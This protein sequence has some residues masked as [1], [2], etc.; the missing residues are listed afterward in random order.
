M[1]L[2]LLVPTL[3]ISTLSILTGCKNETKSDSASVTN[4]EKTAIGSS[5]YD[6]QN[7]TVKYNEYI[8]FQ[9]Y[10]HKYLMKTAQSYYKGFD[11]RKPLTTNNRPIIW[12]HSASAYVSQLKGNTNKTPSFGAID[13]DANTLSQRAKTLDSLLTLSGFYY[14]KKVFEEDSFKKGQLLSDQIEPAFENYYKSYNT[15]ASKINNIAD[16]L[17]ARDLKALKDQGLTIRYN[18]LATIVASDKLIN[19]VFEN[20]KDQFKTV[21][22][23]RIDDLLMQLNGPLSTVEQ[24]SMDQ[25]AIK[26]ELGFKYS[27]ISSFTRES[28][29]LVR[30]VKALQ[31]RIR[32]KNWKFSVTHPNIADKGSVEEISKYYNNL[33][34]QYN[35]ML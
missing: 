2:K 10:Y 34:G 17:T 8:G 16:E 4:T 27:Y 20:E 9:N 14:S 26:K 28:S 21:D 13:S 15:F 1:N 12:S 29:G 25:E 3:I 6:H 22:L 33:I 35:H 11:S 18:L 31:E 7:F 5:M 24:L 32:T 19:Y 30:S 23:T